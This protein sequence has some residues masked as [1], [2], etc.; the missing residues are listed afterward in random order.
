VHGLE[1]FCGIVVVVRDRHQ[2]TQ[3]HET[4]VRRVYD[5]GAARRTVDLQRIR[6]GRRFRKRNPAHDTD[7]LRRK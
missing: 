4:A 2:Q 6:S 5:A 1:K 7:L 3:L